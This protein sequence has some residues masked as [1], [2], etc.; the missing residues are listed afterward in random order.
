MTN[1]FSSAWIYYTRKIGVSYIFWNGLCERPVSNYSGLCVHTHLRALHINIASQ[2][3]C[4]FEPVV[5]LQASTE[6]EPKRCYHLQTSAGCINSHLTV[7]FIDPR[8]T[9]SNRDSKPPL[10]ACLQAATVWPQTM[11]EAVKPVLPGLSV[12]AGT[13][14]D[15]KGAADEHFGLHEGFSRQVLA[16]SRMSCLI[17]PA[18]QVWGLVPPS[19]VLTIKDDYSQ[20]PSYRT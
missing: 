15:F 5:Q 1:Y 18:W 13:M 8:V 4:V 14:Y 2:K 16:H 3:P 7:A 6:P 9:S 17:I 10:S 20:A 19:L 11:G 12:N